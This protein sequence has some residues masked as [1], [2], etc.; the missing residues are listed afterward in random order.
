[1]NPISLDYHN[2]LS[3]GHKFSPVII[4]FFI[5]SACLTAYCLTA[6]TAS[7]A[8]SQPASPA[9]KFWEQ[10]KVISTGLLAKV[11]IGSDSEIEEI[12]STRDSV[13]VSLHQ[14]LIVLY[15]IVVYILLF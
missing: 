7:S 4:D 10:S 8:R 2:A 14:Y 6:S 9:R 12:F 3:S 11:D 1:M 15:I 5:S 13:D